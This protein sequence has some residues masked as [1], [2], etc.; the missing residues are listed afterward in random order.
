MSC[1]FVPRNKKWFADNLPRLAEVWSII[2]KERVTG[3]SHRAPQ[4]REKKETSS[5]ESKCLINIHKLKPIEPVFENVVKIRTE[6]MD[7]TKKALEN[8][9]I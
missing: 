3:F 5:Q 9:E 6:S 4:K 2:E 1:V 8:G 7:E